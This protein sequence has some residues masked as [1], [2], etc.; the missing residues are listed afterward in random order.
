MKRHSFRALTLAA[1]LGTLSLPSYAIDW[2][3]WGCKLGILQATP[4]TIEKCMHAED[5]FKHLEM[6]SLIAETSGGNRA[7]ATP[8]YEK[9]I[10]YIR[11]QLQAVGYQVTLEPFTYSEYKKLGP[12]TFNVIDPVGDQKELVEDADFSL[13]SFSGKGKVLAPVEAIDVTLGEEN[14]SSSGCE[15]EDFEGFTAGHIALIQRGSCTFRQKVEHAEAAGAIGAIIFN[16]GDTEERKGLMNGTLSEE[17]E[18]SL[19]TMFATYDIGAEMAGN[20]KLRVYLDAQGETVTTHTE[21]LVAESRWGN[22]E[23]VVMSGAHLDSVDDGAGINDNGSGSA[24]LL[25]LALIMAK[26]P[27]FQKLKFAWWGAEELGLLGSTAYVNQLEEGAKQRIKAYLNFD[28]VG[29]TNGVNFVYDGD[30][31]EFGL[32]GPKGS[33]SIEKLFRLYFLLKDQQSEETQISFRSDYAAFFENDIAF[34]G[35]FTGAEGKKTERE[36]RVYGGTAG[37]SYDP[38]YHQSCDT[39]E[40]LDLERLGLHADAAAFVVSWLSYSVSSIEKE[41]EESETEETLMVP[42]MHPAT[43]DKP[44]FHPD[45][46]R[47]GNIWFR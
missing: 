12:S 22:P 34:G 24:T 44:E 3:E 15:A 17:Y 31:S 35:L 23:S 36:A 26:Q 8:G 14:A 41:R 45:R 6:F 39:L 27:T 29:S 1:A 9:S 32:E 38:C 25:Q 46:E 16:Q 5:I 47:S 33:K 42:N 18:G 11:D 7:A 13:M 28:M 21:N 20:D 30:G 40:N 19:P 4:A 2:T 10:S 43:F 37:E